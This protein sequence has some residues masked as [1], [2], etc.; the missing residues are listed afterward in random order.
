M[1][2][3]SNAQTIRE[4]RYIRAELLTL[5]SLQWH[6]V[7]VLIAVKTAAETARPLHLPAP[8]ARAALITCRLTKGS[9]RGGRG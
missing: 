9:T 1:F 7:A 3:S 8:G 4:D 2:L 6:A 5:K